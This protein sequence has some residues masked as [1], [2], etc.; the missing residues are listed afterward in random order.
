MVDVFREDFELEEPPSLSPECSELERTKYQAITGGR[1]RTSVDV[2][3]ASVNVT[4]LRRLS[5]SNRLVPE[6][7]SRALSSECVSFHPDAPFCPETVTS[8]TFMSLS[9]SISFQWITREIWNL[10]PVYAGLCLKVKRVSP[11]AYRCDVSGEGSNFCC[12]GEAYHHSKIFFVVDQHD[13]LQQLC[14]DERC[15]KRI[16]TAIPPQFMDALF[17]KESDL[18][19]PSPYNFRKT[20]VP[21]SEVQVFSSPKRRIM[22]EDENMSLGSGCKRRK[23][24]TL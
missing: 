13:G 14:Q 5:V 7:R 18:Q 8:D 2:S 12:A 23:T 16:H 6:K 4:P 9:R 19:S 10:H 3:D 21:R 17:S 15:S 22:Q 11:S 20:R 24:P 1:R